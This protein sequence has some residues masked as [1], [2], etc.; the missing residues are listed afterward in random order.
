MPKKSKDKG[1]RG[2]REA[3]AVLTELTGV[4][5]RRGLSQSRFG[6]AETPDIEPVEPSR[7]WSDWHVEVKRNRDRV[8]IRRAMV[9]AVSDAR[10]RDLAPVVVWRVDRRKWQATTRAGDLAIASAWF[11]KVGRA[12]QLHKG[13][14]TQPLDFVDWAAPHSALVTLNLADW[15]A[16]VGWPIV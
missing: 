11:A 13:D 14:H 3:A 2:E 7:I 16:L 9:Q 4:E 15:V 5:W 1:A 8:D 10:C 12:P 6:G